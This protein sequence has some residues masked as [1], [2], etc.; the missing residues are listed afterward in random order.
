MPTEILYGEPLSVRSG[1]TWQWKISQSDYPPDTW[2]LSYSLLNSAGKITISA[3]ADGADHLVSVAAATTAAYTAGR[4]DWFAHVTDGSDRYQ[5]GTGAISIQPDLSALDTYDGRSHSR[6]MLAAIEALLEDQ[7][8][9]GQID[10]VATTLNS[11]SLTRDKAEL[12]KLHGRYA[13]AVR[14]EDDA[15]RIARGG[16]PAGVT[17]VRFRG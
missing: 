7:A 4:Y 9:T 5:I 10:L 11:R 6:K 16:S 13:A 3:I 15:Q 12:V 1:D 14:A 8:T 17:Q 2:T